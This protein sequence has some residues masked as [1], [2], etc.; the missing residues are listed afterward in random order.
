MGAV[1]AGAPADDVSR[2]RQFGILIGL[3]FQAVDDTL[4][5]KETTG[6]TKGKD[7]EQGKLTYLSL[8]GCEEV[9]RMVHAYTE[10]A[11]GLIPSGPD[12]GEVVSFVRELVARKK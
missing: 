1:A 10:E 2:W 5:N 11:V 12:S 6:K 7:R 3:A 4:D 9:Q 8:H